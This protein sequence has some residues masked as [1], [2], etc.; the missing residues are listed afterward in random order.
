MQEKRRGEEMSKHLTKKDKKRLKVM[1]LLRQIDDGFIEWIDCGEYD[2]MF[3]T[4][5]TVFMESVY[6]MR[7]YKIYR[8]DKWWRYQ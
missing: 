7:F 8:Q 2:D 4:Y 1:R 3:L 5:Y 6:A